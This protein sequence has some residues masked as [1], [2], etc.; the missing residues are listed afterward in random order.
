MKYGTLTF[1][2][3]WLS[4]RAE[5]VSPIRSHWFIPLWALELLKV[6]SG[7]IAKPQYYPRDQCTLAS[8]QKPRWEPY[9]AFLPILLII[10]YDFDA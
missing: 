1:E 9:R 5:A 8:F 6:S 10:I 4:T 7:I 2:K 3:T